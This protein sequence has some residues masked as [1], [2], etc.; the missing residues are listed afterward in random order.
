MTAVRKTIVGVVLIGAVAV[1]VLG[2]W[3]ASAQVAADELNV[4]ATG[5]GIA[6]ASPIGQAQVTA[7]VQADQLNPLAKKR[8]KKSS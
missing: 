8:R 3:T 2:I 6:A 5:R 4:R 7:S 1:D